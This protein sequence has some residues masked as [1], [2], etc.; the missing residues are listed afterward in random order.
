MGTEQSTRVRSC[1]RIISVCLIVQLLISFRLWVKSW[2]TFPTVPLF[3]S[4]PVH[5]DNTVELFFF[6][7]LLGL[8]VLIF[9]FPEKKIAGAFVSLLFLLLI[10]EDS[11]RL[12][13]WVYLFGN[14]F[15]CYFFS[16]DDRD[17]IFTARIILSSVYIWSGLQKMNPHFAT[18]MFPWLAEFSGL[19]NFFEANHWAGWTVAA[20]EVCA[21]IGLWIDRS[22]KFACFGIFAMHLLILLSLGP[23]GHSWNVIVWP[24]NVAFA[25]LVFYLFFKPKHKKNKVKLTFNIQFLRASVIITFLAMPVLNFFGAGDHFLSAGFYSSVADTAVFYFPNSEKEKL[26]ASARAHMYANGENAQLILMADHWALKELNVP[27]YP[28]ER[29][30]VQLAVRLCDCFGNKK[31]SGIKLLRKKRFRRGAEELWISCEEI[32]KLNGE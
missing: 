11:T 7:L 30:H 25:L 1:I 26:P 9:F 27:F 15:L 21:G 23:T 10:L 31:Q 4:L 29:T 14:L 2:R 5:Y 20:I 19:R 6:F 13:P 28:E 17:F 16:K 18:E 22:R 12:Q 8:C 24:W 3:Q 32:K